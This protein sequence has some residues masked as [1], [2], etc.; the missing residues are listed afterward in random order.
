MLRCS[1]SMDG[2]HPAI[3]ELCTGASL[4]SSRTFTCST[5]VARNS[6]LHAKRPLLCRNTHCPPT[7]TTTVSGRRRSALLPSLHHLR[8]HVY[9]T[10]L[11]IAIWEARDGSRGVVDVVLSQGSCLLDAVT[12]DHKISGLPLVSVES[13]QEHNLCLPCARR[14]ALRTCVRQACLVPRCS[15]RQIVAAQS[16]IRAQDL[17]RQACLV[18]YR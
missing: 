13:V 7:A 10:D 17:H 15:S 11:G 6:M 8:A 12:S 2:P 18:L 9:Q 4:I 14:Q 5:F 1:S 16:L 3:H